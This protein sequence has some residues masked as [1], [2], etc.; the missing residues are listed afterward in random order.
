MVFNGEISKPSNLILTEIMA[1]TGVGFLVY[2]LVAGVAIFMNAGG[3]VTISEIAY[4]GDD[5]EI[6]LSF[7]GPKWY[8]IHN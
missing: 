3:G 6:D 7:Y 5:D 2:G 1:V 8:G 4:D